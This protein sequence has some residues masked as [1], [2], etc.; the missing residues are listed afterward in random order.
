MAVFSQESL[1]RIEQAIPSYKERFFLT[2]DLISMSFTYGERLEI[3]ADKDGYLCVN[4]GERSVRQMRFSDEEAAVAYF[5]RF[6]PLAVNTYAHEDD[7]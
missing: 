6:I 5:I 7:P 1:A 2:P 3:Y 4:Q